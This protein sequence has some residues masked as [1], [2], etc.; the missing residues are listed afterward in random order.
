MHRAAANPEVD[1]WLLKSHRADH[2]IVA[3]KDELLGAG[4]TLAFSRAL[5]RSADDS[6]TYARVHMV[7]GIADAYILCMARLQH[8]ALAHW[9]TPSQAL[10]HEL[11]GT[12]LQRFQAYTAQADPLLLTRVSTRPGRGAR[13]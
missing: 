13:S 12:T 3:C 6:V 5:G 10:E 9:G 11:P 1:E 8:N 2:V 4:M 7:L